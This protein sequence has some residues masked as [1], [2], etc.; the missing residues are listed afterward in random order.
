MFTN[1]FLGN[2]L[3]SPQN[4]I[5]PSLRQTTWGVKGIFRAQVWAEYS[6]IIEYLKGETP[7][8]LYRIVKGV[9]SWLIWPIDQC[10]LTEKG[11]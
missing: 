2:S 7:V 10:E 1:F 9:S 11:H 3:V 4:R 8:K 5:H 6:I